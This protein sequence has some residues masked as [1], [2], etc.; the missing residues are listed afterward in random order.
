[1]AKR[2]HVNQTRRVRRSLEVFY[3]TGIPHSTLISQ[4]EANQANTELLFDT[5]ALWIHCRD[6]DVLTQRLVQRVDK[7]MES[8]LVDEIKRLRAHVQQHPPQ[9]IPGKSDSTTH[10]YDDEDRNG[11]MDHTV[12]ILQAIGYKEFSPYLN[13]LETAETDTKTNKVLEECIEQLNIA[14]RQYARRQLSWIR[15]RFVPR[16]IP[17]YQIDSSDVSQW[18][19]MVSAPAIAIAQ[20]FL[21]GEPHTFKTL[22]ELEPD[23][24]NLMSTEEKYKETLCEICGNRKFVGITQWSMHLRSK[25]HRY[26]LR[27]IQIEKEGRQPGQP[28]DKPH[29][30]NSKSKVEDESENVSL[31]RIKIQGRND[32]NISTRK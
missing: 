29:G 28:F 11:S 15:S 1:M 10:A 32:K 17:V 12:G 14:T 27:R 19:S 22:K 2:W 16:N 9:Y 18:K 8:G 7:M 13:V 31:K 20:A 4:Q 23:N 5:C 21:R 3:Q 6:K 24:Y 26:H 30:I 25:G